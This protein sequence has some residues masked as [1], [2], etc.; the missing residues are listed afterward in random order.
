[1]VGGMKMY[2]LEESVATASMKEGDGWRDGRPVFRRTNISKMYDPE[3]R[4]AKG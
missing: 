3:E 2:D 4:V 1:M